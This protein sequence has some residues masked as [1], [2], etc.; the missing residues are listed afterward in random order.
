MTRV[1]LHELC[2]RH[3]RHGWVG[4][5]LA[6]HFSRLGLHD[7]EVYPTTLV[8]RSLNAALDVLG[9][10]TANGAPAPWLSDLRRRDAHDSFFAS[11]TGFTV[12]GRKP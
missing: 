8:I 11:V 7:V 10:G 5:Q 1:L 6:G 4:R 12:R 9:I 2:D 3:I